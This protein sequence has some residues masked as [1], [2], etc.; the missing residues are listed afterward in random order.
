MRGM[1]AGRA[2][3]AVGLVEGALEWASVAIVAQE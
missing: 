3:S 2:S 1:G